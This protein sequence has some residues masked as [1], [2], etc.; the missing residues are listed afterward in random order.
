MAK[1]VLQSDNIELYRQLDNLSE[2]VLDQQNIINHLELEIK[3]LKKKIKIIEESQRHPELY[4]TLEGEDDA[5]YCTHCWDN[6]EKLIQMRINN[7]QFEYPH[8]K[9]K[10]VFDKK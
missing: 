7:G 6:E 3:R 4:L 1:I 5:I 9:L 8:C 10:G 2:Q